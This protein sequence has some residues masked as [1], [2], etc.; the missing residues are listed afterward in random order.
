M[1][2]VGIDEA[3]RGPV[4]GPLVI[5]GVIVEKEKR[6]ELEEWFKNLG[7]KDSKKI[8]PVRRERIYEELIQ[9]VKYSVKVIT[10]EE[11]DHTLLNTNSNLNWLEADYSIEIINELNAKEAILDCPS[12][13][14]QKYSEYV[15]IKTPKI[16]LIVEH[17]ADDTY[18]LVGAASIIAKV[19]RDKL[20]ENIK[21]EIKIDF[22]SGYPSDPKTQE[23]LKK[24]YNKFNIFRKSW[25][26]Y[27][28]II[29]KKEQLNLKK[30]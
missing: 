17:K 11:I 27:Q 29:S 15:Q 5:A 26:S 20:I 30:F 13:N 8:L 3:G 18:L 4:I 19:T 25:S 12:T 21:K 14:P 6:K 10:P 16:R 1:S 24:N 22:G 2:I 9:K 28:K 7:V 23:F